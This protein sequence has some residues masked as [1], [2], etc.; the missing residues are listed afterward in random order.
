M[1][2]PTEKMGAQ[3]GCDPFPTPLSGGGCEG[4][5]PNVV[6]TCEESSILAQMREIKGQVRAI[7]DRLHAIQ[8]HISTA[9]EGP[10]SEWTEL[11]GQLE[12][13]RSQWQDW[14]VKLDEAIHHKMVLLGHREP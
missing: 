1:E 11:S 2:N 8:G 10:R 14:T 7:E 12:G 13:L 3:C 6:L 9:P 5:S 4:C